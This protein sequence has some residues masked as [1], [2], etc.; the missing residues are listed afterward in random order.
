MGGG[1]VSPQLWDGRG[2]LG[3]GFR[4]PLVLLTP[5]MC[6]FE[7]FCQFL[8]QHLNCSRKPQKRDVRLASYVSQSIFLVVILHLFL[9]VIIPI[10]LN[11]NIGEDVMS[12]ENRSVSMN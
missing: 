5:T 10:G 9:V 12:L 7:P 8:H 1:K 11:V 4:S 3:E 2:F 6:V